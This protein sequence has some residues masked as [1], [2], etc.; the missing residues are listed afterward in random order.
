MIERWFIETLCWILGGH[1]WWPE[2]SFYSKCM[3]CGKKEMNEW[4]V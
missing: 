1:R 3:G 4:W 2:D